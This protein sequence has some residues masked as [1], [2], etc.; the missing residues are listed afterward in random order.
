M[1]F[2]YFLDERKNS[3]SSRGRRRISEYDVVVRDIRL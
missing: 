2:I 3:G 1:V